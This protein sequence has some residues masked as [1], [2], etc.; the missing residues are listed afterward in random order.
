MARAPH[1]SLGLL[2]GASRDLEL[3]EV[4]PQFWASGRVLLWPGGG[5][6]WK[7]G[8]EA[9]LSE[10][11]GCHRHPQGAGLHHVVQTQTGLFQPG[12]VLMFG[13][14]VAFLAPEIQMSP[15]LASVSPRALQLCDPSQLG[16]QE[17]ENPGKVRAQPPWEEAAPPLR[18]ASRCPSP[19][20][21][22]LLPP[23]RRPPVPAL[24]LSRAPT[25]C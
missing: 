17:A 16:G 22:R 18:P 9:C 2:G 14:A 7:G 20:C 23:S 19:T 5:G 11:T 15:F 21:P 25:S 13:D 8:W 3:S 12:T 24:C 4:C 6:H 10:G 1:K